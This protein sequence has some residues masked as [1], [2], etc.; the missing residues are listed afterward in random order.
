MIQNAHWIRLSAFGWLIAYFDAVE[1]KNIR[2][3]LHAQTWLFKKKNP[4]IKK[5]QEN[6]EFFIENGLNCSN[7]SIDCSSKK[8][9]MVWIHEKFFGMPPYK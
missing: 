4:E 8:S 1:L 3:K 7:E 5:Y 9:K 6:G 2:L